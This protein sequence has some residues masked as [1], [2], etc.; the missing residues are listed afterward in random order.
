LVNALADSQ[1]EEVTSR[2]SAEVPAVRPA[3]SGAQAHAEPL[4]A[5][6]APVSGT[7]PPR[8]PGQSEHQTGVALEPASDET[9]EEQPPAAEPEGTEAAA[10]SS[11][12][13][14]DVKASWAEVLKEVR[15]H[16]KPAQAL[17]LDSHLVAVNGDEV[18]VGFYDDWH[19]ERMAVPQK[20]EVVQGAM[21][22]VLGQ[23]LR[24]KCLVIPREHSADGTAALR[25]S[26]GVTGGTIPSELPSP[27]PDPP[28]TDL[29]SDEGK[30]DTRGAAG[31][32]YQDIV[33][34]D[35]L[36]KE[37]VQ[38]YGARVTGVQYTGEQ[39]VDSED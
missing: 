36:I 22:R 8:A 2:G 18:H 29:P 28:Q 1:P 7:T 20:C 17:L 35:P 37:A 4:V 21:E 25:A 9:E 10:G 31:D 27:P 15:R 38:K 13:L 26:G 14:S 19:R 23:T 5:E 6:E 3:V 12:T 16:D 11:L 32:E 24:L 30:R 34:T 33:D 39:K